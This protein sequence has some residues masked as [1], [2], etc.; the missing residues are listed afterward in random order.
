MTEIKNNSLKNNRRILFDPSAVGK[1][2]QRMMEGFGWN[3]TR[4]MLLQFGYENG[5]DD[6]LHMKEDYKT[7]DKIEILRAGPTIHSWHGLVKAIPMELC[8]DKEKRELKYTGKWLNSFE[9]EQHLLHNPISQESVCWM[10]MGYASGYVTATTG[11]KAIAIE[12]MCVGKGDTHC[13]WLIKLEHEWD[14][15]IIRPYKEAYSKF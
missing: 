9:A 12:P 5:Y 6:C 7:Q 15:E 11:F 2:R 4:E 3:A 13:E 10:L 1:L 8:F 14:E